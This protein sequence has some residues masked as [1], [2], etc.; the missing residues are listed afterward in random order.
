MLEK[1][2][3]PIALMNIKIHHQNLLHQSLRQQD[4][5]GDGDIIED[6]KARPLMIVGMMTAARRVAGDGLCQG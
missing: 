6:A 2:R 4:M 3:G 5:G 1:P